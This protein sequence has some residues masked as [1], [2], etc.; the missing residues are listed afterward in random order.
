MLTSDDIRKLEGIASEVLAI[1]EITA[2]PVPVETMLQQPRN[3][4]WDHLDIGKLTGSFLA[5]T[6]P[7]SPRMS[8]ARLLARHI[9]NSQ[10]GA[11]HGL[12]RLIGN[13]EDHLRHFAR[14]IIIPREFIDRLPPSSRTAVAI[15]INFEVPE[16]DAASRLKE[17]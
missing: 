2:P 3:N 9:V 4:L 6:D 8:M 12:D 10:W 13:S 16:D 7:F 1:Y 5:V 17:L 11:Q 14:M 15:G